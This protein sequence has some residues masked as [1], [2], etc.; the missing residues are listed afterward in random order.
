MRTGSWNC[1]S[2]SSFWHPLSCK[3]IFLETKIFMD[4]KGISFLTAYNNHNWRI[5]QEVHSLPLIPSTPQLWCHLWNIH[6]YTHISGLPAM[7]GKEKY[8]F[9]PN[10][11]WIQF[12]KVIYVRKTP[13]LK[14]PKTLFFWG[15]VKI[16]NFFLLL[17]NGTLFNVYITCNLK[18]MQSWP[19]EWNG[20]FMYLTT[21]TEC[22]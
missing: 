9:F 5:G 18:I 2:R 11:H 17:A 21:F 1:H 20:K 3:K 12:T 13:H 8:Y 4:F 16:S 7:L 14:Y 10:I 19:P 15:G 22:M 6:Q